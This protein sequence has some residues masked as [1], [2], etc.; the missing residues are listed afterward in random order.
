MSDVSNPVRNAFL[1][2]VK[3][4]GRNDWVLG[5]PCH[6]LERHGGFEIAQLR[7]YKDQREIRKANGDQ[8]ILV[9]EEFPAQLKCAKQLDDA[10]RIDLMIRGLV[11]ESRLG[12]GLPRAVF[13]A[14]KVGGL[15]ASNPV[16][17]AESALTGQETRPEF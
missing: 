1:R 8:Y 6:L 9:M 4:S 14:C 3:S 10:H 17:F 11:E 16:M 13:V 7:N 12:D 5:L 15:Y 2:V